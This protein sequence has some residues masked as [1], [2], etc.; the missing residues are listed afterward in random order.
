[1]KTKR[2]QLYL[3]ALLIF[4][5]A[6]LPNNIFAVTANP[7]PI[8]YVQ[9]DG[10]V[11]TILLKGDEF[12]HWAVSS[13]G[14]TL[15]SNKNGTYEYAKILAD[16]K[17]G[18]SG[19]QA[20]EPNVRGGKEIEFL[21]KISKGIFFPKSQISQMKQAV[22][23]TSGQGIQQ[24]G[25]FPSGGTRKLLVILAN[26][27][28]TS[29]T[30]PQANFDNYMN[31]VNYNGTGS[32]RDYYIE[33]SYGQLIVN[34]TVTAWVTLPNTHDFY[35]PQSMWGQFAF[36]A[37][38]AA[39]N[40]TAVNFADFDNDNDGIVDGVAIFHQGQGQEESA[41]ITDV[42]SHSWELSSAGYTSTQRSFD[43][44][45]VDS[46]TTMPERNATSM[47]TIG[48]MCHEFGH[49][50]GAPDFYD[51]D[52]STNGFYSGT[53][54]WDIMASGSWNGN[55]GDKPAHHN[56]YTKAYVYGWTTPT[57]LSTAQ[58]ITIRRSEIY[59]DVVRFNTSIANE[60]FICENRQQVGFDAGIPGHG[61]M[62][63]HVDGSY[64]LAHSNQNN[65][66]AG[67]HQGMYPVCATANG[68]PP[69]VYGTISGGGCPF[70]GTG[71]KTGFSDVTLPNSKSWAATNTNYPLAN[72]TENN[73]LKEISFCFINC[74]TPD[75][76]VNL[77]ATTVSPSQINLNWA[78]NANNNAV[79]IA[80]NTT[81]V[82]GI[83]V[84]GNNYFSGNAIPGGGTVIYNGANLMFS[85]SGI[86]PSTTYYYKVWSILTGVAYSSGIIANAT[87]L[88]SVVGS[89]PF[90]EGFANTAMPDCWTQLDNQG[91][92]QIWQFGTTSGQSPNP[93]LNGNYAYFN[94]D[95][96]G[97]GN[98]QN[99]DLITPTINLTNYSNVTLAFNHYFKS[100]SGSS[101]KL[102][103]SINN[104]STWVNISTFTAT[105]ASNPVGFSQIIA[106]VAGQTQVKF[107]WNYTGTWGYYWAIDN[108]SLTGVCNIPANAST[109]V[110]S[111]TV[112]QGAALVTYS[113]PAILNASAYI[114]E[115]SGTGAVIAGSTNSINITFASNATSGIL[116][117]KGHS[118]CGD[119]SLSSLAI[120]VNNLP[121]P[122]VVDTIIQ[123]DCIEAGSVVLKGLP[124]S[125]D[126]M[127]TKVPGGNTIT[128]TGSSL[129]ITGLFNGNF[130]YTI[131]NSFGC[132]ST[133]SAYI[134][135][136]QQPLQVSAPNGA[137]T[138]SF[139]SENHPSVANL[140]ASGSNIQ[141]YQ[142]SIGGSPL[143]A[144]TTLVNGFHYWASQ[145][146]N[147]CES[148]SRFDVLVIINTNGTWLGTLSSDWYDS[149]NWCG[150][151]P[152]ISTDVVIRT[153]TVQ[154]NT[155]VLSAICNN[156]TINSG[157]CLD[158]G[159]ESDL[160]VTGSFIN[161]A[162][163]N[164][165]ILES[166]SNGTASLL[167]H[168]AGVAATVKRCLVQ[169]N[170]VRY[171]YISSPITSA[172]ITTFS[173]FYVYRFNESTNA[174]I[175]MT[176]NQS[177]GVL[178]GYSVYKPLT[179]STVKTFTGILNCGSVGAIVSRTDA[180]K[181]W[182]LI[183]NP[184]PSSIDL[185][186]LNGW[187]KNNIAGA[188]YF[189]NQDS[190][191]YASYIAGFPQGTPG[192]GSPF[193]TSGIIPAMQGFMVR[194]V[195]GQASGTI[196]MND[197]VR[198]H[199][200]Q[201]FWKT[202]IPKL[203]RISAANGDFSDE[204]VIR[205]SPQASFQFDE[206]MDAQK[207]MSEEAMAQLYTKKGNQDLSINSYPEIDKNLIVPLNIK[208]NQSGE[209]RITASDYATL[210]F[211][212]YLE[213]ILLHSVTN[214][215]E[216]P[217]YVFSGLKDD[218]PYR[219]RLHFSV[220]P[221]I[222]N[223]CSNTKIKIYNSENT[224]F[225]ISNQNSTGKVEMYNVL[226]EMLFSSSLQN[227]TLN[228]FN[229]S[230]LRTGY[231]IVK[232]QNASEVISEKV[233][234]K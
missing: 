3:I 38:T 193:G 40:Q 82:F 199:S 212:V 195:E 133:E 121:P 167:H 66:N 168:S 108:I 44:V 110:G 211:G 45:M 191:T 42:W 77:T 55:I 205:F 123:P 119:G 93:I 137:A 36:D 2:I 86:N 218:N 153:G 117:V 152:I 41:I 84:T 138:Q 67:S 79:L 73:A 141:W 87:T 78:Q 58:S 130:S 43:G 98:T 180:S 109:I 154:I 127:L 100:Y 136:N 224:L 49:N 223:N 85:H 216:T 4:L 222:L 96:Y 134:V 182:N 125:G 92:G 10:S 1:M 88:C 196:Q 52:Y 162:G 18:F 95:A 179:T 32:F 94:S 8:R 101:G 89:L 65:I 106:A 148:T 64:I 139:C 103:Y 71:N 181:G 156:L 69:T 202:N 188:A 116:T 145:K 164:G 24:S 5:I 185:D 197:S 114:W 160:T 234:V 21:S 186:A 11:I 176:D 157:A 31:Q 183:G 99:A 178:K 190:K 62:I 207:L 228:S 102:S 46:Y 189:W 9:P 166:N 25:G 132:S 13:D 201:T 231:Y 165:L 128:G 163:N 140:T 47:G 217:I 225:V 221:Q 227:T 144:S 126:W 214:L 226:G 229:L 70:P 28:N 203:L 204:A 15:L 34:T 198:V 187:T 57:V 113:V 53:G 151:V 7:N 192:I 80:Y 146:L 14:Y 122:P 173:G 111:S 33:V 27:S 59:S 76:P 61:L 22:S 177:F 97:S 169:A 81:P 75:D 208:I 184:Y 124:V 39:N 143:I 6:L 210:D 23:L 48:V 118:Q 147:G 175:N 120:T 194:V 26:F 35:G 129:T 115:Y 29:V 150:G 74:I 131:T 172:P 135:I 174:W 230:N 19:I 233:F 158:I 63:Y 200:D 142:D 215:I 12:I 60:F 213:D 56:A 104:G 72:I 107:K 30:Y 232:V 155:S 37:I 159:A 50:L 171:H 112:C 206:K 91:N 68:N 105:S 90:I 170:M 149:S 20:N 17:L 83:P 54:N 219:F 16:G 209:Y 161:N 51:T 220:K